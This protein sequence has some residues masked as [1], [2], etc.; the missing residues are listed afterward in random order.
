M[1]IE[2]KQEESKN[3]ICNKINE[4]IIVEREQ[5]RSRRIRRLQINSD[6]SLDKKK[7]QGIAG[8]N[9]GYDIISKMKYRY[10]RAYH[11]RQG[12]TPGGRKKSTLTG[13]STTGSLPRGEWPNLLRQGTA[14]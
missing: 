8:Q 1:G 13:P 6:K 7:V 10:M 12:R 2:A 11:G 4:A 3:Q 5:G 14:Y 9:K